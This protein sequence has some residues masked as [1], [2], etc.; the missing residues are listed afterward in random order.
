MTEE[1]ERDPDTGERPSEDP[2]P[3]QGVDLERPSVARIYDYLL[4]GDANWAIDRRFGQQALTQLPLLRPIAMSN[5][6]FLHRAVRYLARR[7]VRQFVD[8]GS[9]VPTMGNTHAVA[10]EVT[11]GSRVVY[12]DHEPV[13]VAHSQVL[14]ERHGDLSRHAVINADFRD[15]DRLW[16]RVLDTGVLNLD[17]PVAM[18][19]I[20]VL[21]VQQLGP[22]GTDISPQAIARYRELL[23][24]GSYMGLSHVTDEGVP[25]NLDQDLVELK[26]IY[27]RSTSPVI[28][29]SQQEIRDLFGDFELVEPGLAWTAEWHPEETSPN[30]P[31]IHFTTPNESVIQA[32]VG[33]KVHKG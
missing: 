5:R 22:D 24:E 10:D 32:G 8:I 11:E 13:A 19:F 7:G 20:A 30:S 27:D 12:I 16:N 17:E 14:L 25:E 18:L 15:P 4:G 28:W 6:L 1:I 21:H 31:N 9:G 23:P 26:Q 2:Y 29:R 33:R 3:P